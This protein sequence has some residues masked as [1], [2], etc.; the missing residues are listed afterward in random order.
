MKDTKPMTRVTQAN[1][2]H[3]SGR[4]KIPHLS[5]QRFVSPSIPS[6][7]R[8][9]PLRRTHRS[10]S[11]SAAALRSGRRSSDP[12]DSPIHPVDL[13]VAAYVVVDAGE[14][15]RL[16][17]RRRT[18]K[19]RE[20][21]SG[22]DA[23]QAAVEADSARARQRGRGGGVACGRLL[24]S[25]STSRVP[26]LATPPFSCCVSCGGGGGE[27]LERRGGEGMSLGWLRRKW[28][29]IWGFLQADSAQGHGAVLMRKTHTKFGHQQA[30]KQRC[31]QRRR[32]AV[33][34]PRVDSPRRGFVLPCMRTSCSDGTWLAPT[35]GCFSDVAQ[36]RNSP[37]PRT[38]NGLTTR[39]IGRHDLPLST[40]DITLDLFSVGSIF[41]GF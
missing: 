34:V 2:A 40:E 7:L 39:H 8:F 38:M 19:W 18:S 11:P 28:R 22:R 13:V 32:D 33:S 6:P 24:S 41:R 1:R 9:L 17:L 4:E 31:P 3:E 5:F 20:G 12:L 35:R 37:R 16:G 14:L 30:A 23:R 25:T 26:R 10:S 27:K 15:P 21:G 36:R 29:A